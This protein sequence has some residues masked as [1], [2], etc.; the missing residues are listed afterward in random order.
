MATIAT[1]VRDPKYAIPALDT[2]DRCIE[3]M[4]RYS[5]FMNVR[6]SLQQLSNRAH[7]AQAIFQ[8]ADRELSLSDEVNRPMKLSTPEVLIMDGLTPSRPSSATS[9]DESSDLQGGLPSVEDFFISCSQGPSSIDDQKN[10]THSPGDKAWED[11]K[12][13]SGLT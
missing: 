13:L 5:T 8:P 6:A 3:L 9:L 4:G 7:E 11:F 10:R 12:A 1:Q 2:L